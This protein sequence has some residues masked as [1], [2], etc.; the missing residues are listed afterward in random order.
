MISTL[1]GARDHVDL[2]LLSHLGD[3]SAISQVVDS[4]SDRGSS[5]DR[6]A[7]IGVD[8]SSPLAS[9]RSE[10]ILGNIAMHHIHLKVWLNW[11]LGQQHAIYP[12]R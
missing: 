4:W 6:S 9:K 10:A 5:A 8:G 11:K 1:V 12:N 7:A 2:Q 3:L